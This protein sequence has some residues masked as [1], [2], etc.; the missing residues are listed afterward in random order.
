[1]LVCVSQNPSLRFFYGLLNAA[2]GTLVHNRRPRQSAKFLVFLPSTPH[3]VRERTSELRSHCETRFFSLL[4][5]TVI[6]VE[7]Q[8]CRI[9]RSLAYPATCAAGAIHRTLL[10]VTLGVTPVFSDYKCR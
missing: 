10:A 6:A 5:W 8:S 1:M 7:R 2:R 3:R 9:W 4:S